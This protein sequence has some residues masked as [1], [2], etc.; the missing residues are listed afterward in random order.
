[1]A[2]DSNVLIFERVR[3]ELRSGKTIPSAIEQGFARAFVTII[4]THVTTI[5][6]LVVPVLFS[7]PAPLRGFAVTLVIVLLIN[8]FSAGLC[9][10]HDFHVGVESQRKLESLSIRAL[11]RR[12]E[13]QSFPFDWFI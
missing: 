1:M 13:T 11:R 10:A 6:F 8:L 7:A 2:V 12:V 9:L 4:D 3:E 5:I